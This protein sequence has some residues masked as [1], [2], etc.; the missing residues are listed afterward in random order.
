MKSNTQE[1]VVIFLATSLAVLSTPI[2][3]LNI[4]GGTIAFIWLAILGKWQ[5]LLVGFLASFLMP[6]TYYLVASI[7]SFGIIFLI[8]LCQKYKFLQMILGAISAL[9]FNVVNLFWVFITFCFVV[10]FIEPDKNPIPYLLCGYSTALSPLQFMGSKEPADSYGTTFGL[11][12]AQLAY[13]LI[14]V[15]YYLLSVP[16]LI[17][18]S[19]ILLLVAIEIYILLTITHLQE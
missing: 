5:L 13:V 17:V 2:I 9:Y 11:I 1:K 3:F 6:H 12:I 14:A 4:L 7:P 15:L 16:F 10:S 8:Q 18:A 19:I